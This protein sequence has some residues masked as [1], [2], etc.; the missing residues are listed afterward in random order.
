M[1]GETQKCPMCG[2]KLK[3]MN[4]RMTCKKCGYY[5]RSQSEMNDTS[6]RQY[7][8]SGQYTDNRQTGT[9]GQSG[10]AYQAGTPGQ[11]GSTYR[12]GAGQTGSP[13]QSGTTGRASSTWQSGQSPT[14]KKPGESN[15]VVAIVV[16]VIVGSI[17]VAALVAI[18]LFRA[19]IFDGLITGRN[20]GSEA[21]SSY[22]Y[23]ESDS[24]TQSAQASQDSSS[25][26]QSASS[27]RLPQSSFFCEVAEAVWGKP[28][29]S[30]SAE[31]YASLTALQI[32]R[33]EKSIYYQLNYGETQT[34]TYYSDI[35]MNLADLAS[36]TGL[37]WLSLDADLNK[38]DLDGLN[39]LYGVYAE[40]TI[41][42]LADIIPNPEYITEIGAEDSIFEHDLSGIESFPSLEYLYV[43]YGSLE[44]IS[45]LLQYPNLLSLTLIDCD[46][47]N[48]Y[49][50]LMSL[51]SLESLTI[52][53]S[54]LKSIDFVN[55][56]PSLTSLSVE[57]SQISN[58]NALG[59]CPGLEVLSLIDNYD[60][61]DYSIIGQ[62]SELK[63]LTLEMSYDSVLPSFENLTQI[64][65]LTVKNASDLTPLK[66]A[67]N[68]TYL[69]LA[70]CAGWELESI[71]AMQNLN[72][73]IINDFRSYVESLEPLTRL[74]NLNALSLEDTSVFG[75]IEEIFGIPT[76][77]YL[78]LDDCQVGIDFERMPVNETL[79]VLSLSEMTILKDPTYNNG[80]EI[81]LSEHYDMFD[82]FPNLTELY[83]ASLRLDSIEFVSKLPRLQYLDITNN[84]VTSLKPLE[85][86]SDF[87]AVWCGQNTILENLSSDSNIF[88]YTTDY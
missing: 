6:A 53:S 34:L 39:Y 57:N 37:E 12:T 28:Y 82:C 42:D 58:I 16:S 11:T 75:N 76:L 36:F 81:N 45:A 22:R 19:G 63:D 38:G 48:D 35:G 18:V 86:L 3:M 50:P 2:T 84:S 13:Y 67:V 14:Q 23:S 10:S 40:N 20:S 41:S 4:G 55:E 1:A 65:W 8:G 54:Q 33:D 73:L 66:D 25:S 5:I 64:E 71:T 29:R 51:N 21:S 52:A 32:D 87:Q 62:L 77:Q 69:S 80:D 46:S 78:Y 60:I 27:A 68:V 70:D 88:V 74:P 83:A 59:N 17:S 15:P 26:G 30:I 7:G 85:A 9:A 56:M 49:S 24:P 47:L 79:E 72:T 43:D 44:D 61:A 31:E